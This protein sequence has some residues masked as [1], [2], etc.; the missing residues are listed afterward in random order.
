MNDRFLEACRR[1]PVDCTPVWFMRQ[2]GR[3]MA[4]Y[5][6]LREK[7]TLLELCRTPELAVEVT[8]QPIRAFGVRRRDPLLATSSSRSRRW[9]SRSTSRPARGRSSRR[10]CAAAADV[11]ALRRFEPREEL[12][13]VLEAIRLLRRELQVPLIGFAGAP[14][15]LASYAIEGGHSSNFAKTKGLMY[16][17]PAT[18][19]RLAGAPRRRR[20]ATTSARRSRR[21]PRRCSSST[22]GSAPSTRPTTASSS[23]P[24]SGASSTPSPTSTSR[25]STSGRAPGTC[26]R[27]SARPAGR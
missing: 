16:G 4:E 13:M 12:G 2:A 18:W 8:L 27:C 14:F 23:C 22:R 11:A 19:H 20:G 5:R 10:R 25:R 7:H 9:A 15:T 17:E 21:G 1:E 6:A 24:T 26:S 3:Y